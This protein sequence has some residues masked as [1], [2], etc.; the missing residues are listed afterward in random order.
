MDL[1][2][3]LASTL[4]VLVCAA[5][6]CGQQSALVGRTNC[7]LQSALVGWC[8]RS[9]SAMSLPGISDHGPSNTAVVGF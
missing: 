1:R 2:I 5:G 4:V 7:Q 8:V 9:V 6:V 3:P